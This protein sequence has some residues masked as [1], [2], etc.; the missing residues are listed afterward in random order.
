MRTAIINGILLTP[1][2]QVPNG[3]LMIE[4]GRITMLF[5]GKA[6][7]KADRVIDAEGLYVSPGFIDMHNHGGGGFEYLDGT[8][9]AFEGAT[10]FHM[11]HGTT[12]VM[13]T[14]SAC[15]DNE[16]FAALTAFKEAKCRMKS[17]PNLFG[18]YMEGPYFSVE[19]RGA[20]DPR[21]IIPPDPAHY[22]K[23]LDFSGDI[24]RW[25]SSPE[26]A[27]ALEFADELV[28]RGILCSIAHSNATHQQVVPAFERGYTHISHLYSGCSMIRRI[29][30]FRYMGVVDSAYAID[31]MTVEII[32]DGCHLP[33]ELL[34]LIVKL[35]PWDKISLITDAM[36]CAGMPEGTMHYTGTKENGTN[37]LI[38]DGVAKLPDRSS[39]AG[40]IATADRLVRNMRNLADVPL[41][42][43]VRMMTFNPANVMGMKTKGVL[44]PGKDADICIFDDEINIATVLVNGEVTVE[45]I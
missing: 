7:G 3:G 41:V 40:S 21:F 11:R 12:T 22:K 36:R 8:P 29:N 9:E 37:V 31:N 34:K 4:D 43:A 5:E 23:I 2:R 27:G 19:E 42:D 45:K 14:L 20:Q 30:A 39:F 33:P 6:P 24:V 13:P 18:I 44:A 32:A 1:F 10:K 35:K 28:S 15:A 25:S 17:G 16:L 38:E 26:V